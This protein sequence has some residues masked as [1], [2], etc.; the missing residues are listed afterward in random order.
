M[1]VVD[2][3]LLVLDWWHLRGNTFFCLPQPH[4]HL[5]CHCTCGSTSVITTPTVAFTY[6]SYA[7]LPVAVPHGAGGLSLHFFGGWEGLRAPLPALQT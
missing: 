4:Y 5:A 7:M 1:P 3:V 2:V 6:Y